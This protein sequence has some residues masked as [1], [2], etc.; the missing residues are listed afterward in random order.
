MMLRAI[1]SALAVGLL[2]QLGGPVPAFAA[3]ASQTQMASP[4]EVVYVSS[5]GGAGAQRSMD[6]NDNWKFTLDDPKG[7]ERP[8]FD[9]SRWKS[10]D[11]PHDY[12]IEQ[13]YSQS[14]EAESG[15][16]PGG[17]GWYRKT[18]T[19]DESLRNKQIRIDFDGVYMDAAVYVNGTP[20]GT[21]PYGYTPFSF[22]LTDLVNFGGENVIAVRV[23]HQIPS[24]RWYS[25][26]GIYRDVAL[27]VT[28]KVH[29]DLY[30]THVTTPGLNEKTPDNYDM[31]IQT[32]VC[33]D[34]T[35]AAEVVL[36]HTLYEKKHPETPR[37]SVST[38]AVSVRPGEQV[39]IGAELTPD[40]APKLWS[41]AAPNLYV[42]R[43][44]VKVGGQ[45]KDIYDTDFGFRYF[46]F[47]KDTGF[48]LN[49]APLKLKGV[50]MHH[51]QGALGAE[52]HYDAVERQV[53]I[54]MDMGCN[55]IRVTHN[56]ASQNLIDICNEKGILV[57]EE[58]FD[59]WYRAKNGN[60][61]DF[62]RFFWTD[63]PAETRLI[64]AEEGMCWA[65]FS[66]Q[67]AIRRDRS[68]PSVIL[69][70]L[71]NEISEGAGG[72][73]YHESVDR[74]I[75]WAREVDNI[76]L[77]PLT[78]GSNKAQ[79]IGSIPMNPELSDHAQVAESL[80]AAGGVSGINYANRGKYE[81]IHRTYP[82]WPIYGSETASS[83]NS[84][85]IYKN[86]DKQ[87]VS[88]DTSRVNWGA[89][90]ND[91]W[92]DVIAL[93][94][95]AGEYVWTGFDYL[96]EPTPWNGI[97]SGPASSWPSPKNSYFGI[98]DTAGLPKDS[99][100]LYRSF[101]N[102]KEPTIH[103]LPAW[104]E[105]VISKN[106][107]G[108]TSVVVYA[109]GSA[110]EQEVD[111]V[112]LSFIP[113]GQTEP[114]KTYNGKYKTL[115]TG[116]GH[117]YQVNE[118]DENKLYFEFMVPFAPGTLRAEALSAGRPVLDK[119]GNPVVAE[120]TTAGAAARLEAEADRQTVTANGDDL[121]YV[122]IDV[123][124]AKG[125]LVPNA[126]NEIN[127]TVEGAGRLVGLDNGNSPD[128]TSF[129]SP[130]RRAFSGKLVAIVQADKTAGEIAVTASASG[131][132]SSTVTVEAEPAADSQGAAQLDAFLMSKTYYV[133]VGSAP[134]LPD[135]IQLRYTDGS[136]RSKAVTWEKPSAEQIGK[137]NSFTLN[138]TV[139]GLDQKV[140]VNINM[141]DEVAA[142]LNYSITTPVGKAPELSES[143]P[144]VMADGTILDVSFPV[145]WDK[146]T[147]GDFAAVGTR[148][149]SGTAD[150]LGKPLNVRASV[151]VQEEQI[152]LGGSVSGAA[153]LSQNIPPEKQSDKLES[154]NDGVK[155]ANN[156]Q[157]RWSNWAWAN[158]GNTTSEIVFRYATQQR[159]GQAVIYFG[160]DNGTLT[161]PD[162]GK[163]EIW[164]SETGEEGSY[165]Q[166]KLTESIGPEIP[167]ASNNGQDGPM[168]AYTYTFEPFGATF[169]KLKITNSTTKE[170]ACTGIV[171][172]ELLKA[173][174]S[175]TINSTAALEALSINSEAVSALDLAAGETNTL[176]KADQIKTLEITPAGNAAVTRLPAHEGVITLL[177]ESEDHLTRD[178]FLI[179]LEQA[180][181]YHPEDSKYDYA[182]GT[183][184]A[185]AKSIYGGGGTEG[186]TA[187]A[188][189]GRADT[190]WHTNWATSEAKDVN[191][192]WLALDLGDVK[193][194]GGVRYLPRQNGKNGVPTSYRIEVSD[195]NAA[196][197]D[198]NK[199]TWTE[200]PGSA[201]TWDKDAPGWNLIRFQAPVEARYVRV[202][203]VHTYADGDLDAHMSMAELRALDGRAVLPGQPVDPDRPD[204][205]D[206]SRDLTASGVAAGHAHGG[207]P[208]DKVLDNDSNSFWQ[209]GWTDTTGK[210]VNNRW[211][212]LDLGGVKQVDG[213]RVLPRQGKNMGDENGT[214]IQY[215][216]KVRSSTQEQW[217]TVA[218]GTRP[219]SGDW[220]SWYLLTFGQVEARYVRFCGLTTY[221]DTGNDQQMSLAEFR[222]V[223]TDTAPE[224]PTDA[225][226]AAA[227]DELIGQIGTVTLD[228]GEQIA[229]ARTAYEG[230]TE[231]QQKLV[232]KLDVLT[233]AEEQ[234]AEL[235]KPVEFPDVKSGQWFYKGVQYSAKHG[236]IS[237]LPDGTFGPDVKMS[238]AQLVQMLYAMA[239]RPTVKITDKFADVSEGQ[240]FAAAASWAVEAGVTSGVGGGLFAPNKEITRQEIAVMLH[241]FMKKAAADTELTFADNAEI[242]P[243]AVPSVKWAVENGL[244]KGVL[245]NKFAPKSLATR[246]EAATIM[247]NLD[248]MDK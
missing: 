159:I 47:D 180:P 45:V 182:P 31:D 233:A 160:K 38:K 219:T 53:D 169:V 46:R 122:E 107:R 139:E 112:R 106:L 43:T 68:A 228:S 10:V 178:S 221:G 86:T 66:L 166:V 133:K 215:A 147:D 212:E 82:D 94:F 114:S 67:S 227:V 98:I 199:W 64:H 101:W 223:G 161:Y 35:A 129:Q 172:V 26:S 229:A 54:L 186:P 62:A 151:R 118:A 136:E 69:W 124:D 56:P 154:I 125:V 44:E 236:I 192:R 175:Y 70:S 149:V 77:R 158:A 120:I 128:H 75:D 200:V 108:E 232:T 33:N 152:T 76:A 218:E 25:G 2:A 81:N 234:F 4:P 209:T 131:L 104:N 140:T 216:V 109:G 11:L 18:F 29:V 34:G 15:Y 224:G 90:A 80:V 13:A 97:Y 3:P 117:T 194:I 111:G 32:T 201:G 17:I 85:G 183:T 40:G 63:I 176:L 207:Y 170:K 190:H 244:M 41:T 202:V 52:N 173:D 72:T 71:G 189:D 73:D 163:T 8:E 121:F 27:T 78:I 96:G 156:N 196:E 222:A 203:G 241:A 84:R 137:V 50:C 99:Y 213:V 123:T 92:R 155:S 226:L 198:Y 61:N 187:L 157:S 238:R 24:S 115:T 208:A 205:A 235:N 103:I 243:W 211:I 19:L 245:G 105:E 193:P 167:A 23:N 95:V 181:A 184:T 79:N 65:E 242:A 143:R 48:Y 16:L 171:E 12:S 248:Q 5:Y 230:L 214:P 138:G 113:A 141:I 188:L 162:P 246:A 240:W 126:D 20:L 148:T 168:K 22:D 135:T 195:G 185:I 150:V 179:H 164:I 7:A 247:M 89:L 42:V 1:S 110:G 59:G 49:G 30:G 231:D 102:D 145:S 100:Y 191:F 237:G 51:D 116:A 60:R 28:D 217:V 39:V 220:R 93:D 239:G 36:T 91:A 55:S 197:N 132:T 83:I 177:L 127:V 119:D 37:G 153:A 14:L 134:V 225:E 130:K 9:A 6:F 210:D 142:L 144:A 57:I 174:G 204:P 88:Y 206:D 21:H 74:L 87:R 58:M 146:V 165:Q